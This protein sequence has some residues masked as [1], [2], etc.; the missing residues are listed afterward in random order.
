MP[1]LSDANPAPVVAGLAALAAPLQAS[2]LGREDFPPKSRVF[3][4]GSLMGIGKQIHRCLS[5]VVYVPIS[6]N[7]SDSNR[8]TTV[9]PLNS[10]RNVSFCVVGICISHEFTSL[11]VSGSKARPLMPSC[12]PW[13]MCHWKILPGNPCQGK[14][15]SGRFCSSNRL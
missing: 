15:T 14:K 4:W 3:V 8:N 10:V 13:R 9:I 6:D 2:R 11:R 1:N 12:H 5:I 7:I